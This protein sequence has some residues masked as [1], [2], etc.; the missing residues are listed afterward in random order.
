MSHFPKRLVNSKSKVE[1]ELDLP[2]Y[3][4]KSNL[5][6]AAGVDTSDFAKKADLASLKADVL[7]LDID[8]LKKVPIDLSSLKSKVD[9]L[10]VVKMVPAHTNVMREE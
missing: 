9:K 2:N 7:Q 8:K 10:D 6:N 1:V 3:A 5:K 4:Q